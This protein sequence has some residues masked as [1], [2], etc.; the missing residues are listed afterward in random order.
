[1]SRADSTTAKRPPRNEQSSCFLLCRCEPGSG[2]VGGLGLLG[3]R[4]RRDVTAVAFTLGD[5]SRMLRD[6]LKDKSYRS[7]PLG[8]EAARYIRW[9]RNEWGAT[10]ETI[11]DYEAALAKLA[12]F[13]ADLELRDLETPVGTERLRECWDYYWGDK[14]PRT[15]K[16]IRSVWNDF[17]DWAI[18]ENRGIHGNPSRA[19]AAPRGRGVKREPFAGSLV[20]KVVPAQSYLAD[21]LGVRLVVEYGVRRA[22]LA[23]IRFRDFD[24][25]RRQLV[26]TGKAGK[27]RHVGIVE[28]AF[29]RDL[30]AVQLEL[31]GP[32][33]V[34]DWFL[35]HQRERRGLE[36]FYYP[37][38]GYVP[39]SIHTWWYNRLEA[40]GFVGAKESGTRVGLGMHR[41]RH[42]VAT[43]IL[44]GSG[45]IVAAQ[46]L[47][48][49]ADLSTTEEHYASF[50]TDDVSKV[51]RSVRGIEE[52]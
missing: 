6:G 9:K 32:E 41:G 45:N 38:K 21:S 20:G 12:L 17:F 31:G 51:L 47:L 30:G 40:A 27:I 46:K 10:T 23:A 42:T 29:W 7:T 22:E 2:R 14:S 1:M 25:E 19:M 4:E 3:L 28:P 26:L 5:A 24:F 13:F 39:R 43:E 18:R 11:R 52:V 15:R 49:H 16:K 37:H 48:G 34:G 33:A 35:I 44:R 36:T 8:L 50:D